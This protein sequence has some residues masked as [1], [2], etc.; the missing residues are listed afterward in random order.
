M[1]FVCR[2]ASKQGYDWQFYGEL[3]QL[4]LQGGHHASLHFPA[5]KINIKQLVKV[6]EKWLCYCKSLSSSSSFNVPSFPFLGLDMI[7]VASTVFYPLPYLLWCLTSSYISSSTTLL[8]VFFCIPTGLPFTSSSIA[9]L[10]MLFSYLRF[11]WPNHLNLVFYN[12]CSRFFI[13]HFLTF[14]IVT[15]SC[16]LTLVTV[17]VYFT[18]FTTL[19]NITHL[20]LTAVS[21]IV[22][23]T[24]RKKYLKCLAALGSWEASTFL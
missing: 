16:Y 4:E 3:H 14:S 24:K 8:Q 19:T 13:P 17:N 12:L 5:N 10:S 20:H 6:N 23:L 2:M 1:D 9:L 22:I 21:A 11:T 15:Q 18:R 7:R